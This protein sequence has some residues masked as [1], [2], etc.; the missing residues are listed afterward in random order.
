MNP[1]E[2]FVACFLFGGCLYIALA[3]SRR[4]LGCAWTLVVALAMFLTVCG[5][6]GAPTPFVPP[7]VEEPAPAA[8]ACFVDH[9]HLDDHVV[10]VP[11]VFRVRG[12][13]RY[14]WCVNVQKD[15]LDF[16]GSWYFSNWESSFS[17]WEQVN[18]VILYVDGRPL[19]WILEDRETGFDPAYDIAP[20]MVFDPSEFEGY[21]TR[22]CLRMEVD[23]DA[24]T[25]PR[26][27]EF[28]YDVESRVCP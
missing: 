6:S 8:P 15:Y 18:R 16:D 28:S 4:E 25:S 3:R 21:T 12:R 17:N 7:D 19:A 2:I 20:H 24:W 13:I 23:L 10:G 1:F 27:L 22:I 14:N 26:R 11:G 9:M 5:C